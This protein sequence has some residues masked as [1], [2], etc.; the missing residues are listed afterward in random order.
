MNRTE[1]ITLK[2][3]IKAFKRASKGKN[4]MMAVTSHDFRSLKAEVEEVRKY[5]SIAHKRFPKVKIKFC[6]SLEGFRKVLNIKNPES[7]RLKLSIRKIKTKN[8]ETC[9]KISTLKG[10]VFGPQPYLAMK[11]KNGTYRHD[12]LDFGLKAGE[13]FYSVYEDTIKLSDIKEVAVGAAD[14]KGN[15][16]ICSIKFK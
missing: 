14:Q 4:T 12:N 11:L 2:E 5:I 9:F 13:W 7:K 8:A 3:T 15:F 10:K 1:S 16:D 6:D